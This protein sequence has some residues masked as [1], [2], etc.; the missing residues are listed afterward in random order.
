MLSGFIIKIIV[1]AKGVKEDDRTWE[2][3]QTA[4]K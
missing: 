2:D 3:Y 1:K 4:E